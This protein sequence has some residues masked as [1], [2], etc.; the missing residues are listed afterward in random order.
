VDVGVG[1][2]AVESQTMEASVMQDPLAPTPEDTMKD[3]II[4]EQQHCNGEPGGTLR[5]LFCL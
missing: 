3:E 4:E 2:V 1:G 5:L